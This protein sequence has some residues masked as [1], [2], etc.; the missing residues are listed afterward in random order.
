MDRREDFFAP[1][2]PKPLIVPGDVVKSRLIA[3]VSGGVKDMKSAED[4][5]LPPAEIALL[6]I[7]IDAGANWPPN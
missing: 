5:V 6:K 3:I 4:H 7:W 1:G 2:D